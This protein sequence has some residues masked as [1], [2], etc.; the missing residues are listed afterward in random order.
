MARKKPPGTT[1]KP[2]STT[3]GKV[4]V[5]VPALVTAVATPIATATLKPL[6]EWA[7]EVLKQM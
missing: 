5:W 3:N 2:Q 4:P 7:I 6:I 1:D